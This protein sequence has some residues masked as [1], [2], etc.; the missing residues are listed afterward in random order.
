MLFVF[1]YDFELMGVAAGSNKAQSE[2]SFINHIFEFISN[3]AA[4]VGFQVVQ[5]L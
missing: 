1:K 4:N 5:N 2:R 3:N